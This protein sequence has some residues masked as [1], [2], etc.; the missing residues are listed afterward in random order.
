VL[1]VT[2]V[3]FWQLPCVAKRLEITERSFR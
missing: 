3:N 1:T 2:V